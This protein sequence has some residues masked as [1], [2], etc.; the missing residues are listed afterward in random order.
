MTSPRAVVFLGVALVSSLA[1]AQT[2]RATFTTTPAPPGGRNYA[3]RN[4][5]A[6][7]VEDSSGTFVKTIGR[8]GTR[9]HSNLVSWRGKAGTSDT[10]SISGATRGS[11]T[12]QLTVNWDLRNRQ[13]ATVPDGMYTVRME[14]ADREAPTSSNNNQGTFTFV[15]SSSSQT[16]SSL[17]NGGFNAVTL[18]FTAPG[19]AGGGTS[20]TGGGTSGTGGGSSGTGGGTSG[21]GGGSSGTGGGSSGTTAALCTR[22]GSAVSRFFAGNS[23]CTSGSLFIGNAFSQSNCLGATCTPFDLQTINAALPCLEAT[24]PC[25][26]GFEA[27]ALSSLQPCAATLSDV[28]PGCQAAIG[29]E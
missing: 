28:S 29:I 25:T 17:S 15:K 16:Q 5:V 4:V 7:W 18:T 22:I 21:T 20:G 10:D 13:G 2:L 1:A 26:S 6:V 27:A 9:E 14:L 24:T 23:T 19:G 3:P 12:A 11:H 8:W